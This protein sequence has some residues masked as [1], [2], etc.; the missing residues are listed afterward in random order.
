MRTKTAKQIYE[1]S[2]RLLHG[3][4]VLSW[5]GKEYA[6]ERYNGLFE[7]VYNVTDAY[8]ANIRRYFKCNGYMNNKQYETPVLVEIY[9]GINN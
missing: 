2:H 8:I 1:Q 6:D 4:A 5:N 7:R 9:R 3:L